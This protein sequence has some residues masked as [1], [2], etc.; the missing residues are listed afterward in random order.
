ME[1]L[2][3]EN[4]GTALIPTPVRFEQTA[5]ETEQKLTTDINELWNWH[6]Q[7]QN[8]VATTKEELK[9]IRQRLGERLHM[10]KQLLARP[11][12]NG[13]WSSFLQG[14]GIPRTTADRLVLGHERLLAPESNCANGAIHEPTKQDVRKLFTSVWPRL[15]KTLT[16]PESVYKFIIYIIARSGIPHQCREEG[17]VMFHPTI[18]V[19]GEPKFVVPED[20]SSVEPANG[21]CGD[22]L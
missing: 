4:I 9:A 7:A 13:Q 21:T 1:D 16:K 5:A 2:I 17:I 18:G 8:T 14:H 12:R 20:V 22:I 11:G 3:P 19:P 10:M 6:V 15:A